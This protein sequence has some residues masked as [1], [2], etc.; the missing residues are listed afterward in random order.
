[1]RKRILNILSVLVL[2]AIVILMDHYIGSPAK[3]IS[4]KSWQD[5]IDDLPFSILFFLGFYIM[6]S[7]MAKKKQ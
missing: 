7:Y 6:I 4:P 5:I 2:F 3:G 1:M